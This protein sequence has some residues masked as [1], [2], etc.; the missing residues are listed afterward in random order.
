MTI[1][2]KRI[3]GVPNTILHQG[4]AG[5]V[6]VIRVAIVLPRLVIMLFLVAK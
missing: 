6:N 5:E 3:D 1:I 4:G 2:K